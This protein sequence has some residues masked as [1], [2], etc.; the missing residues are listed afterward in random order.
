[1]RQIEKDLGNFWNG[2]IKKAA[3]TV[4]TRLVRNAVTI[5]GDLAAG[6]PWCD[7]P[8]L[9]AVM[10][11]RVYIADK[12]GVI[13]VNS[14]EWAKNRPGSIIGNGIITKVEIKHPQRGEGAG[15]YKVMRVQGEYAAGVAAAYV[16]LNSGIIED[17]RVVAGATAPHPAILD[18]VE[19]AIKGK[20]PDDIDWNAIISMVGDRFKPASDPRFDRDYR[21]HAVAVAVKR[22]V[23]EAIDF[24]GEKR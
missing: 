2:V 5:G 22:A 21:A 1:M 4:G 16:R 9:I 24:A 11:A 8:V 20:R 12:N 18:Y 15:F 19:D 3:S 14:I 6:L 7:M 23:L 13:A 17:V 10:P